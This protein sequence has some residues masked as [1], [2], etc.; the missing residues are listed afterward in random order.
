MKNKNYVWMLFFGCI[1]FSAS[2]LISRSGGLTQ[3]KRTGSPDSGGLTCASCHGGG[4]TPSTQTIQISTNIPSGGFAPNTQ[5]DITVTMNDGGAGTAK[6]GFQASVENASGHQGTVS[7]NSADLQLAQSNKYVTHTSSSNL[8]N[9]GIRSWTFQWNSGSAPSG[10]TIYVAGN[11]ANGNGNNG[12]D[13]IV[14]TSLVLN[15]QAPISLA[16]LSTAMPS[17]ILSHSAV[18]G[19]NISN[20][21]GAPISA[22]GV[23]Y[24]TSP[25]PTLS[26]SFTVD[27]SGTGAFSSTLSGLNPSTT[28]YVRAYASNSAGTAYGNEVM[29]ATTAFCD[30]INFG[31]ITSVAKIGNPK[32]YRAFF[33]LPSALDYRLQIKSESDTAWK[34]SATWTNAGLSQQNFQAL[35]FAELNSLRLGHFDGSNWNY[36]CEYDFTADCKPMSLSTIELVAPFCAGDS[37][38]LKAITTGGFK[39]KSFLWSTGETTRFIYGQ[40]GQTYSV[41]VTDESGCTQM[42]MITVGSINTQY[43][44]SAFSVA[45]PNAV[46]F[47]GSW[48]PA[49]LGSGVNLIGYRMAYRQVGVGASWTNT[50]LSTNTTATVNFTG[51]GLPSANYEF[52]V[53][54]RVNDNGTVYNTEYACRERKFYNGSGNKNADNSSSLNSSS[55]GIHIY[56]NPT[57]GLVYVSAT[58]GSLVQLTDMQGRILQEQQIGEAEWVFDLS[59]YAKGMYLI[60][61]VQDGSSLTEQIIKQ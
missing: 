57:S 45:K 3:A 39:L 56:P 20:D 43:T 59:N 49:S 52:T 38:L 47:T 5:Y 15:Q 61:L 60:K 23:V 46:T 32:T 24:H 55:N 58:A 33:S 34:T 11:F 14:S 37:A 1:L 48:S 31:H 13:I 54:A 17:S 22:R 2:H 35:D 30:T 53:F 9:G 18:A 44:P 25:S 29:F 40:Q 12:G 8:L 27:G 7:E 28:Y 41:T 4:L 50:S 26:N 36:G 10:T 6:V 21:G 16:S 42:A 19:G 51:S